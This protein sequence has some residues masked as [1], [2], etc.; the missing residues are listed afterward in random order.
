M[1]SYGYYLYFIVDH[2][3]YC[4]K[5]RKEERARRT[6]LVDSIP[7][8]TR[9]VQDLAVAVENLQSQSWTIVIISKTT[10]LK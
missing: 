9:S 5:K 10:C 4:L 6:G 3:R 8:L 1:Y 7:L 2:I